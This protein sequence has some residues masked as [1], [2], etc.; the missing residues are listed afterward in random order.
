MD[1]D[2]TKKEPVFG[3]IIF[4]LCLDHKRMKERIIIG[5]TEEVR[6]LL[7]RGTGEVYCDEVRPLGQMVIDFEADPD[8]LWNVSATQLC[9]SYEKI[10]L[11]DTAR[12]KA[13]AQSNAFLR[14]KYKS[15]APVVRYA[16][17]RMWNE[18]L[19]CYNI[20][21]GPQMFLD[22]VSLL[23][24]PFHLYGEYRPW[25]EEAIQSLEKTLHAGE[26]QLELWYPN[27]KRSLECVVAYSSFQPVI[28]YYLK[29]LEEWKLYFLKCKIC[30]RY[31]VARS[32]RYELCGK[33][34][35]TVQATE[36]KRQF[37]ERAGKQYYEQLY[38]AD[39]NYWYNRLRKVK[40]NETANPE[41][42]AAVK[43]AFEAF[44]LEA[45]RRKNEVKNGKERIQYLTDFLDDEK[46]KLDKLM[47]WNSKS[48]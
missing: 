31:F 45:V 16:A 42:A 3:R 36:N 41:L 25:R 14:E 34:C 13:T 30:G 17:M 19:V 12:W 24:R 22:R 26:S 38:E 20:N 9:Q 5:E 10:G 6:R 1:Y 4:A 32:R 28:F 48:P 33:K 47:V 37:D 43:E 15:G 27:P 35:R 8:R 40:K 44:R 2:F 46:K 18:Y 21:H 11:T 39:Y 23:C 7:E 29:R